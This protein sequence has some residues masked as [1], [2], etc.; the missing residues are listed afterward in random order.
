MYVFLKCPL[1]S[2]LRPQSKNR[3]KRR[4]QGDCFHSGLVAGHSGAQD[5]AACGSQSMDHSMLVETE[6]GAADGEQAT[7]GPRCLRKAR[8]G[9]G[10]ATILGPHVVH[11][12]SLFT[13]APCRPHHPGL[14]ALA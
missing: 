1:F 6:T 2:L 12:P 10:Q 9:S 8:M 14:L 3:E 5:A 11:P 4:K 7:G 13:F